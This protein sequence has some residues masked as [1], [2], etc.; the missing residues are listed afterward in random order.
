MDT[1]TALLAAIWASP[2]DDLPRL[3]YAD[4]LDETGDPAKAARAEFIR[5]QCELARVGEFDD[6]TESLQEAEK[7]LL[8]EWRREWIPRQKLQNA[9]ISFHR[10]MFHPGYSDL[11]QFRSEASLVRSVAPL[12]RLWLSSVD[13][14]EPFLKW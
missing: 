7:R 11:R 3:V 9:G 8:D 5:V 12:Y 10:G 4:W 1:E 2:H 13:G 14:L 6:R